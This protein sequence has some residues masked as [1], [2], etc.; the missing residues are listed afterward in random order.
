MGLLRFLAAEAVSGGGAA[1]TQRLIASSALRLPNPESRSAGAAVRVQVGRLRKLLDA[2]YATAGA[3]EEIRVEIPLRDYRLRFLRNGQPLS[4]GQARPVD[5]PVLAV[6]ETRSLAPEPASPGMAEAFL[7]NILAELGGHG[8]V[9]TVGPVGPSRST[10]GSP[11]HVDVRLQGPATY[12]LDTAVQ[13]AGDD[14]RVLANLFTG[15]PPRQV[16]SQTYAFPAAADRAGRGMETAARKLAADVADES[17]FVVRDILQASSGKPLA[18]LTVVE[19]IMTLW[20][21]WITG[22]QDDLAFARQALDHAV[23]AA[24][25]SPLA[26]AFWVAAAC[27]DYT[28][29]VDPRARLPALV[30]ERIDAARWHVIVHPWIELV[31]GY[32]LWLDRDTSALPGI[33]DR[34]ETPAASATFRGMLGA[35]RIAADME[36]DRGRTAVAGAIAESPC[37]LLWFRLC[38]AIHDMERGEF[39]AAEMNLARVD[40][41]TW[42][43]PVLM[44]VCL[45]SARGDTAM[46]RRILEGVTAALPEFPTVGEIILRRWLAER[47]VDAMAAA[48]RPLGIDWFHE[49]PN[50]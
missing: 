17:G 45:A 29:S 43:E 8:T 11:T 42:P 3:A 25:E 9:T 22:S 14:V 34:L 27:Q 13:G 15:V 21:Y 26:L 5:T 37:P 23:A 16:W 2:Y 39:A 10:D 49:P 48:L 38:A 1:P 6:T 41:P 24:P 46:A 32:V 31:R 12:V 47:H 33:L 35:L 18:D 44:R 4:V 19:S 20:R 7:R 36:P 28:S 30:R 50:G 40:A